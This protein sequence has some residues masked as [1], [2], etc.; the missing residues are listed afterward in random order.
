MSAES[1]PS[2]AQHITDLVTHVD[3][4][5]FAPPALVEPR[6][7]EVLPGAVSYLD[8]PFA[9]DAG[10][11]PLR[12][13]LHVPKRTEAAPVVV[14]AHA[15]SFLAG[16]KEMGPWHSLP[17]QG[18]A[19]ASVEYRLSG[20]VQFPEPIEDVRA[21]IRWVRVHGDRFNLDASRVAGWGSS[22]GA[23]LMLMAALD[24]PSPGGRPLGEHLD[25]SA[26]LSAVVDH[27]GVTDL[28]EL[29]ADA[30]MDPAVSIDDFDEVIRRFLGDAHRCNVAASS[31]PSLVRQGARLPP[32]LIMHGDDDRRVGI[33]QSRRLHEAVAVSGGHSEMVVVPEADHG[34]AVFAQDPLVSDVVRFLERVW[35]GTETGE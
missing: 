35:A 32:L 11:R 23:Y 20:E 10:W 1:A 13:D 34:D 4:R 5:Q 16:I 28:A 8:L 29:R 6:A 19:V 22:A 26:Q 25:E 33:G 18:I 7:C 9:S 30:H 15:G 27:Y 31:V 2:T 14:Y 24:G 12:L 21:A 3:Y 17:G